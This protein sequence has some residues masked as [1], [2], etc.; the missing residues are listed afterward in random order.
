MA[1][2]AEAA[3]VAA[4]EGAA[5]IE[6]RDRFGIGWRPELA[7]GIAAHLHRI[8][9]VEVIADSLFGASRRERRSFAR[10]ARDL[11]VSLHGVGLGLASVTPVGRG[12]LDRMARLVGEVQPESW[13]EHLAFVRA[14]GWEIGHM[15]A[16]P[17]NQATLD[18]LAANLLRAGRVVGA[19]PVLENIATLV[20]P[21][22]SDR[23]EGRWIG[24]VLSATGASLLLDL[25][26][27]HANATNVGFTP[28]SFLAAIP[29]KRIVQVHIA[30]GR[31]VTATSGA[32]RVVDDHLHP[33]PDPVFSLL[34]DV[35][36]LVDAPVDVVLE[37]DGSYP[38]IDPLLQELD[39]AREALARGR[40]RRRAVECPTRSVDAH[41]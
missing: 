37:R 26:N 12:A 7:S 23:P 6:R 1:V 4:A 20:E 35:G 31:V 3:V 8:D 33:V 10:L 2:T 15:A 25:H 16:A 22:G 18:G 29:S 32:K 27:L 19:T 30:G 11:P 13:S 28:A 24:D 21:P 38:G 39:R 17:R 41:A 36:A 5:V 14:G 9:L 34:E 40:A